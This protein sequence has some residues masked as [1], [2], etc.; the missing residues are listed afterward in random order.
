MKKIKMISALA[1]SLTMSVS[2][3]A[4]IA[5]SATEL[6]T[7]EDLQLDPWWDSDPWLTDYSNNIAQDYV[8]Y[9]YPMTKYALYV[10]QY[11]AAAKAQGLPGCMNAYSHAGELTGPEFKGGTSMSRDTVYSMA[12]VDLREQ[13]LLFTIGDDIDG[14]YSTVMFTDFFTDTIGYLERNEDGT[15]ANTLVVPEGWEGTIPDGVDNVIVS[16]TNFMFVVGRTYTNSTPEDL[17]I[18]KQYQ[19]D[20][21]IYPYSEIGKEDPKEAQAFD[22][23]SYPAR[24]EKG[25]ILGLYDYTNE[26]FKIV[27]Y[28]DRDEELMKQFALVGLGP[29]SE[30]SVKD[31]DP[32][33]QTGL[34]TGWYE[35]V[36]ILDKAAG[37]MGTLV[38]TTTE[39]N[40]WI[41]NPSNWGRSGNTG[42]FLS[43]AATQSYAGGTENWTEHAVKLRAFIDGNGETLN[44][45]NEYTLT[46]AKNNYPPVDAFWSVALY[47]DEYN[48][49]ANE[50][51]KY[52]YRSTEDLVYNEDGSFTIYLSNVNPNNPNV[53]WLPTPEGD[54]NI[55]FRTY[56]PQEE[57]INQTYIPPAINKVK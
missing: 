7:V 50:I 36:G 25:D 35:A 39:V 27:G 49:Y 15:G 57:L 38:G 33:I 2:A 4:P 8:I 54:F 48:L 43:R 22:D 41:Y 12:W 56:Y 44:G 16:P 46:F 53:N 1:L 14:R 11:N 17:A 40:G 51:N 28:P 29:L 47:D 3:L 30:G 20:Y 31:L 55:F 45:A 13:P 10:Y 24:P 9:S 21:K 5:V 6:A 37:E 32:E 18:V 42:D 19:Q 52:D 23:S 34:I 26:W